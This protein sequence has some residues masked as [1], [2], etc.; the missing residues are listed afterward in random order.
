MELLIVHTFKDGANPPIEKFLS[1]RQIVKTF[2]ND[3][4]G[5]FRGKAFLLKK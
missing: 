5:D 4:D 1:N 2:G 3:L